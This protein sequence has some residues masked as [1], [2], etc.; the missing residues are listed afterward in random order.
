MELT[1]VDLGRSLSPIRGWEIMSRGGVVKD[2][3]EVDKEVV[4]STVVLILLLYL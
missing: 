2:E 1:R 3:Y 4:S